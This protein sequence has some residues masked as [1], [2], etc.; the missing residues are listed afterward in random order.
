MQNIRTVRILDIKGT[1]VAYANPNSTN[2]S[3]NLDFLPKGMHFI[4]IVNNKQE[5]IKEKI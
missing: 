2:Y 1:Q 3:I 5:I 4:E